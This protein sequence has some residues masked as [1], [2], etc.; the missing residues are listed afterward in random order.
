MSYAYDPGIPVIHARPNER[1]DFIRRTYF[2]LA[3]A[4]LAFAAL[5][6]AIFATFGVNNVVEFSD[7]PISRRSLGSADVSRFAC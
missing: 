6:T 1:A 7:Q 3:G 4:I 5:E 2:H